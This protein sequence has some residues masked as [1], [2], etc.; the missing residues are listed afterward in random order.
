MI[1][2]RHP[3]VAWLLVLV[4]LA[5]A[6][7][8]PLVHA[9]LHAHGDTA[10]SLHACAQFGVK[11]AVVPRLGEDLS[12]ANAGDNADHC[13]FCLHACLGL[14]PTVAMHDCADPAAGARPA[15]AHAQIRRPALAW[16]RPAPR[17]PPF[18]LG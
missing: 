10:A 16:L 4:T 1:R 17:A 15:P 2:R 9:R 5:A 3:L 14:P 11:L 8:P 12:A 18:L 13:P 7:L 6:V